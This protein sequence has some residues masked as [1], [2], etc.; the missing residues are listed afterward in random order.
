MRYLLPAGL[1]LLVFSF[2]ACSYS[3]DFVVVNE[4][5]QPIEVRYKIR[6][7]PVGP[8]DFSGTPSKKDASQLG[9]GNRTPWR[10]A[11]ASEFRLDAVNR[12]VTVVVLPHEALWI[13]SMFHYIGDEDPNDVAN[14]PIEE[15]SVT[16]AGGAMTFTGQK[17]RQSFS[18]VSRTLYTL[19]YK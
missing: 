11:D 12:T 9:K 16:G 2:A 4:S 5:G 14:W 10:K 13:T 8:R 6:E 7:A 15:I 3:T 17:S 18:Y 19:I 1:A